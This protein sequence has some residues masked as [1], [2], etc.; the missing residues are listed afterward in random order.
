MKQISLLLL[1]IVFTSVPCS[2]V[3][4]NTIEYPL[5]YT[6][7]TVFYLEG[8]I[9]DIETD[10]CVITPIIV[11]SVKVAQDI[12]TLDSSED[13]LDTTL[14]NRS[15]STVT[16]V[17]DSARHKKE[18]RKE[19]LLKLK[20]VRLQWSLKRTADTSCAG[21][22]FFVTPKL[23]YHRQRNQFSQIYFRKISGPDSRCQIH[24]DRDNSNTML[25]KK[26]YALFSYPKEYIDIKKEKAEMPDTVFNF[27][28]SWNTSNPIVAISR[29]ETKNHNYKQL[30]F[31]LKDL[32]NAKSFRKKYRVVNKNRNLFIFEG[33]E[34]KKRFDKMVELNF[35]EC[36]E[37]EKWLVKKIF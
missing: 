9:T 35:S 7:E 19:L 37:E 6:P 36:T 13:F 18:K 15:L 11:D 3:Y 31:F 28:S 21:S 14:L 25:G 32:Y 34:G 24:W 20:K 23:F 1:F 29:T 8:E 26:V 16:T 17:E 27:V 30:F 22:R 10:T 2:W 12:A 5:I 4:K 33:K